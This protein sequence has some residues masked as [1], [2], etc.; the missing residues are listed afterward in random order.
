M[1][2]TRKS[3]RLAAAPNAA[4]NAPAPKA[5][6]PRANARAAAAAAAEAARV[7]AEEAAAAD[8]A[9]AEMEARILAV[10]TLRERQRAASKRYYTAHKADVSTRRKKE[11]S[12]KYGALRKAIPPPPRP[13]LP[14]VCTRCDHR[15]AEAPQEH[16]QEME[17]HDEIQHYDQDEEEQ[18]EQHHEQQQ[19]NNAPVL[20]NPKDGITQAYLRQ[21]LD[22]NV[23][24]KTTA[25]SY[26]SNLSTVF[27]LGDCDDL[28]VCLTRDNHLINR[29][30]AGKQIDNPLMDYAV[31]SI[32]GFIQI[33]LYSIDKIPGFEKI[34]ADVKKVWQNGFRMYQAAADAEMRRKAKDPDYGVFAYP[35]YEKKILEKYGK[36][37]LQYFFT[38]LY[39]EVPMRDDFSDMTIKKY[40]T[41]DNTDGNY[42][43]LGDETNPIRIIIGEYK[44]RGAKYG[45]VKATLPPSLNKMM[46]EHINKYK[47]V[48]GNKL[49]KGVKVSTQVSR[50][51]EAIGVPWYLG[52]INYI[53]HSL[54]STTHAR[55]NPAEIAELAKK[56]RHAIEQASAAYVRLLVT[57]Y[58]KPIAAKPVAAKP[59]KKAPRKT[60]KKTAKK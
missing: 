1:A 15:R 5:K 29:I 50:M 30:I 39:K 54:I 56:M 42:L 31:N 7:A 33:V 46:N 14:T 3:A 51:N 11:Y 8:A 26:K 9:A 35:L 57:K 41:D 6:A 32:K 17:E 27:R 53:R 52:G 23:P 48:P 22:I 44:T 4:P 10:A 34:P 20:L 28:F 16:H 13:A 18:Q 21:W 2:N 58:K 19:D 38:Q 47:L 12:E 36:D 25:S 60:T 45:A 43:I 24:K 49:F 40:G 59:A 55:G 37:S